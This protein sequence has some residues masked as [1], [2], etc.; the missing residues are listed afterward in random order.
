M[1]A[2]M[3]SLPLGVDQIQNYIPHR[4]PFLLIDRIT[5]YQPGEGIVAL[6]NVSF[7]DPYLQGHFPGNPVMPGVLQIEAM[8][9]A[10]A[11]FGRLTEPTSSTCLLTEVS[12]SRFRRM[13]VPGDT[14]VL[15]VKVEKRRKNFFWF[16]GEI[17]VDQ[18]L[19]ASIKLS[20]KLD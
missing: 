11:V 20:A 1:S 8:A 19:A 10:C 9:Q 6:K 14:M 17:F 18:T 4:Y 16:E 3:P 12:E 2:Q 7:T 5:E 15:K 13:V